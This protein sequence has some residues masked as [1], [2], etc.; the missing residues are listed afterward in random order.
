M[1]ERL[2]FVSP[3]SLAVLLKRLLA[4][5]DR[6]I[7]WQSS[8]WWVRRCLWRNIVEDKFLSLQTLYSRTDESRSKLR[9]P[10]LGTH[11]WQ[12]NAQSLKPGVSQNMAVHAS[13]TASCFPPCPI[14]A[15]P[16][17]LFTFISFFLSNPQPFVFKLVR[18]LANAVSHVGPWNKNRSACS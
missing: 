8:C 13:L 2:S 4:S 15:F 12:I 11:N 14:S 1:N 16:V 3:L 5:C 10:L 6:R 18:V 17:H 9:S 7:S